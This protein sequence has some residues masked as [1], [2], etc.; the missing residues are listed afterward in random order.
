M[1]RSAVRARAVASTLAGLGAAGLLGLSLSQAG[2]LAVQS[3]PVIGAGL[4]SVSA[5]TSTDLDVSHEVEYSAHARAY[6]L[7]GVG[8]DTPPADCV[9]STVRVSFAAADGSRLAELTGSIEETGAALTMADGE[10]LSLD[11]VATTA[12]VV[13]G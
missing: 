4:A 7:V 9:G 5:C 12:I 8:V 1:G 6:V 13:T 10:S 2:Q 11:A 3:A